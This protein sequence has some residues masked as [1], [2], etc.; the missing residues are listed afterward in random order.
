MKQKKKQEE[1][2]K[3]DTWKILY[4]RKVDHSNDQMGKTEPSIQQE[5]TATRQLSQA[6]KRGFSR[7]QTWWHVDFGLPVSRAVRQEFLL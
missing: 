7:N 3:N 1:E 4:Q 6:K 2:K 5:D